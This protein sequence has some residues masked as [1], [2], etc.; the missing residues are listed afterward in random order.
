M[1]VT[2]A[3]LYIQAPSEASIPQS[4]PPE[5]PLLP[6]GIEAGVEL[7]LVVVV[8]VRV[9]T[10]AWPIR[11]ENCGHV[12]SLHQS[13]AGGEVDDLALA[14]QVPL[15]PVR[16][17]ARGDVHVGVVLGVVAVAVHVQAHRGQGAAQ[18]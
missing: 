3:I 11:G 8:T 16:A 14:G 17:V 1:W 5:V 18:H 10:L 4:F 13:L 7:H 12:T 9:E 6:G 15:L 2:W